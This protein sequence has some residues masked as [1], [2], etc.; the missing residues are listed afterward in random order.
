MPALPE[1][2]P[3][4]IRLPTCTGHFNSLPVAHSSNSG[5]F[6]RSRR[7]RPHLGAEGTGV[8]G[9]WQKRGRVA[10][11]VHGS[12]CKGEFLNPEPEGP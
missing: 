8:G 9:Q 2:T 11:R 3:R 1:V 12:E 10:V 6:L 4:V 5:R 7:G